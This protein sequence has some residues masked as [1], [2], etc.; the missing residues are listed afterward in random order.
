[1]FRQAS[2]LFENLQPLGPHLFLEQ[3]V[4]KETEE[5]VGL[6]A[7]LGFAQRFPGFEKRADVAR[8]AIDLVHPQRLELVELFFLN[9]SIRIFGE[10]HG[11]AYCS[12]R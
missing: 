8:V 5:R 10:A 3:R 6:G 7:L 1:M 12:R 4:G 11:A 9:Q 2:E